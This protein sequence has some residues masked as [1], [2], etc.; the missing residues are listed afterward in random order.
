MKVGREIL[1]YDF[2]LFLG[3]HL[4]QLGTREEVA[5]GVRYVDELVIVAQEAFEKHAMQSVMAE[6]AEVVGYDN[7]FLLFRR[8]Q[9]VLVSECAERMVQR[10]GE[11]LSG[12]DVWAESHCDSVLS[13]LRI[14]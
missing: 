1:E 12:V 4:T 9:E 10:W 14:D 7:P 6:A 5:E 8:Y 3:G 11:R 13:Y 2:D